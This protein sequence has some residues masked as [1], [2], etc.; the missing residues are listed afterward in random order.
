ME[1]RFRNKVLP[2]FLG[3]GCLAGGTRV[4]EEV[5]KQ[6][7]QSSHYNPVVVLF[8]GLSFKVHCIVNQLFVSLHLRLKLCIHL[9]CNYMV[10][11]AWLDISVRKKTTKIMYLKF[12]YCPK[13]HFALC[14]VHHNIQLTV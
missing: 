7:T 4:K 2:P 9:L 5:A 1:S 8:P 11:S 14:Q 12:K 13:K 6:T 10:Q 3:E